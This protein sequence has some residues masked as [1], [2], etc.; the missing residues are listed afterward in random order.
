MGITKMSKVGF[1]STS[2]LKSDSFLVGNTAYNPSFYESIATTTLSSSAGSV[3][4]SSIPAT[5]KHL[6]IRYIARSGYA[7]TISAIGIQLTG[8]NTAPVYEHA[9]FGDGTDAFATGSS[10]YVSNG[11]IMARIAGNN[12]SA[13]FFGAGIID[14]FD[15]T[16]TTNNKTIRGFGGTDNNGSGQL[17]INSR[18]FTIASAISQIKLNAVFTSG[19]TGTTT[20]NTYTQFALY[21]I[22]G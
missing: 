15:Y 4:F 6:Q 19:A 18:L 14:I 16:S 3:T 1:K 8:S 17:N 2:Y 13:N 20:F 11:G 9:F 7:E 10:S 21:G 12:A 22:K 5:F